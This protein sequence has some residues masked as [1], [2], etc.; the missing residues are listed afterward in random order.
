[1][2]VCA[3]EEIAVVVRV[4]SQTKKVFRATHMKYIHE[5]TRATS[6]LSVYDDWSTNSLLVRRSLLYSRNSNRRLEQR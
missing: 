1:V 4:Q 3:I 5:S 6:L 2:C